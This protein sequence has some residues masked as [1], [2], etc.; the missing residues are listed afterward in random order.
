MTQITRKSAPMRGLIL[1]LAMFLGAGLVLSGCGDDDEPAPAP[2]PAPPPPAPAPEPEPE[3][4]TAPGVPTGLRVSATGPT[5]IE[6]SWN[7]VEG[8]DSYQVQFSFDEMFTD[9]DTVV[10]VGPATSF[11]NPETLP[12]PPGT[13]VYLRVRAVAGSGEASAAGGWSTHVTGMSDVPP[14]PPPPMPDPLMVSFSVP[15]GADSPHP[16]VADDDDDEDTAMASVNSEMTVTSNADAIVTPMFVEGA[17][18]V[19]VSAGDSAPFGLVDWGLLQSAVIESGATFQVARITVGA[20]Q[21]AEPTGDVAYVTCGPF[22]CASGMDAPEISIA[23]SSACQGWDPTLTLEVGRVDNSGPDVNPSNGGDLAVED[24]YDLGWVYSSSVAM[25]VTHDF[26]TFISAERK[27]VGKGSSQAMPMVAITS[28][29]N[30][31]LTV[32]AADGDPDTADD[33]E[34]VACADPDAYGRGSDAILRPRGCFRIHAGENYL[35]NYEVTLTPDAGVSWGSVGFEVFDDL[36]CDA[37]SYTATDQVDVCAL[38]E[39]EVDQ[40]HPRT[41]GFQ[42]Y[43]S[44]T[45]V[46]V[47]GFD[48]SFGNADNDLSERYAALWYHDGSRTFK[49]TPTNL[50]AQDNRDISQTTETDLAT[51]RNRQQVWVPLLDADGDPLYGDLGK[52][53]TNTPTVSGGDDKADNLVGEDI[54][55]A[56]ECSAADGG[57]AKSEDKDDGTLCDAEDV[58]IETTVVFTDG[59][60]DGCSVERA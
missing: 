60:E 40:A 46:R 3:A 27:D 34:L 48:L 56:V 13:T 37:V 55:D 18:G 33:Q 39:E 26:G 32:D 10:P 35:S 2:T 5:F 47:A 57:E 12:I 8:A 54:D 38:F 15:D 29:G 4:P 45:P 36:S 21:E 1:L 6:W 24:G 43:R 11:R 31:V 14:P 25:D 16:L 50:Y 30:A 22:E 19:Q 20:N 51:D 28:G 17:S 58:V 7:A 44:A 41:I 53:D 52:V 49:A 42:Y 23:N 9:E 59:F